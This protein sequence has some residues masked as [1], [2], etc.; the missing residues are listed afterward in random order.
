MMMAAI[1]AG[2]V[3][4]G[5]LGYLWWKK[6]HGP[7]SIASGAVRPIA[8]GQRGYPG[9][10]Y[11]QQAPVYANPYAQSM[12]YRGKGYAYSPESSKNGADP[13]LVRL[14]DA[15]R[16]AESN[17]TAASRSGDS[18]HVLHCQQELASAQR[19]FNA[20]KLMMTN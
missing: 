11:Q 10:N 17:L 18:G 20:K 12:A 15:V 7:T 8:Y 13:E 2:V 19:A 5:L 3:G 9:G 14:H 4:I 1:A 6:S 16:D